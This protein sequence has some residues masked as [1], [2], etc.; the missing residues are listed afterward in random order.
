MKS[1]K[2]THKNIYDR[3]TPSPCNNTRNRAFEYAASTIWGHSSFYAVANPVT[4]PLGATV[5]KEKDKHLQEFPTEE[6]SHTP[7]RI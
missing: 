7:N 4:D 3:P 6:L 2:N 1:D 5:D